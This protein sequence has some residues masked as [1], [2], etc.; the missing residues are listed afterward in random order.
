ML[1]VKRMR[2]S[3][4]FFYAIICGVQFLIAQEGDHSDSINQYSIKAELGGIVTTT[5]E[6]PF[7]MLRNNSGRISEENANGLYQN[8]HFSGKNRLF[9]SFNIYSEAEFVASQSQ[10]GVYG[11]LIQGNA[12]IQNRF[13]NLTL[14]LQEEF[15][16]FNDSTLSVGNIVYGNNA[17]PIPKISLAT[18]GWIKSPV[19]KKNLSFR[20]YLAHGWFEE[21]RFQSGAYLH[22]KYFYLKADLIKNRLT[23]AAGLN[24]IAQWGGTNNDTGI[25]QPTGLKNFFKIFIA[26]SGG[27]DAVITDQQNALGNHLG[28]YD[29]NV[30]YKFGTFSL[31]GYWQFIFEDSSGLKPVKWRDGLY[32]LTIKA[33]KFKI[34]NRVNFEIVTTTSQ[35]AVKD[36]GQGGTYL[37]PDNYMNNGIYADG[38]TFNNRVLGNAMFLLLDPEIQ[39]TRRVQNMLGG[40]SIG[41]AGELYRT[42]YELK[43]TNFQNEGLILAPQDPP[44]ELFSI[45]LKTSLRLNNGL[46][47]GLWMNYQNDNFDQGDNFGLFLTVAKKLWLN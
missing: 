11:S 42:H 2:R 9:K 10:D 35:D 17:R 25:S 5:G 13:L 31:N 45:D 47:L 1:K 40:W 33:D 39:G 43:V 34:I 28:S 16:G 19:L 30:G 14:G 15:F 4:I 27:E 3:L 12:S 36:D 22:Q 41:F 21:N 8:L 46:D 6:V 29:F 7:W 37:E 44:Y 20:A 24:H 32:G 38:W 26:A 23:L 18:N